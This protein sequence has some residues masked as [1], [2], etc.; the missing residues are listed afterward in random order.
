[1]RDESPAGNGLDTI[2]LHI[3]QAVLR[4][5]LA[6]LERAYAESLSYTH[7]TGQVETRADRLTTVRSGGYTA[8]TIE[9]LLIERHGD[10][11]ITSGRLVA[12]RLA[13]GRELRYMVPFVRVYAWREG[14]W[15]ML[16]HRALPPVDPGDKP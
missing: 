7:A 3:E 12:T 5:D 11:G 9:A 16:S 8:R 2:D 1:M 10:V 15:Q 13:E 6:F 14:R 4:R